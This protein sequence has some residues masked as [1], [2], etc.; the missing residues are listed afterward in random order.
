MGVLYKVLRKSLASIGM[1]SSRHGLP[2]PWIIFALPKLFPPNQN[3]HWATRC[4]D[5]GTNTAI[6]LEIKV[7]LGAPQS[8]WTLLLK[9]LLMRDASLSSIIIHHLMKNLPTCDSFITS[10]KQ[11][12]M[13]HQYFNVKC[14]AFLCGKGCKQIHE[15]ACTLQDPI[16]Q[17]NYQVVLALCYIVIMTGKSS[18]I[19]RTI[20]SALDKSNNHNWAA[21]LD[22]R[23]VW[24]QKRPPWLE[25]M[26]HLVYPVLDPIAHMMITA[27]Q[28]G[29]TLY[30]AMALSISCFS[31]MWDCVPD[32]L[33]MVS[34]SLSDILPAE[35]KPLGDSV[36][37]QVLF[38]GLYTKFLETSEKELIKEKG[39]L[40]KFSNILY[41]TDYKSINQTSQV[42]Q[43]Y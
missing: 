18:D 22:R 23:Q 16:G 29:A 33:Y 6:A 19:N 25:A 10:L 14:T 21:C 40:F 1:F 4:S 8:N 37:I 35:V 17:T 30:Q 20:I 26:V 27:I 39:I 3:G 5:F 2:S 42:V 41:I 12:L 28:S 32:C 13:D 9:I 36:L 11:P 7:L 15:W 31:E 34:S 24:N 43:Q 38:S